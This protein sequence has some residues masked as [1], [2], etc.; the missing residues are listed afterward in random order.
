MSVITVPPV[1]EL[2]WLLY[3]RMDFTHARIL[4]IG[5]L[6]LSVLVALVLAD[7]R[8][9]SPHAELTAVMLGLLAAG[10]AVLLVMGIELIAQSFEEKDLFFFFQAEDGIR[11]HCV[12]GVQ[13]CA[14]PISSRR[15]RSRPRPRSFRWADRRGLAAR[16]ERGLGRLRSRRLARPVHRQPHQPG[17]LWQP[18]IGRASCRERVYV[19]V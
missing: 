7:L 13:T 1:L 5:L 12:T 6:S 10:L 8:P 2:V 14:L 15:D 19:P 17:R 16:N 3:L 4:I 11:D 18:E 9:R